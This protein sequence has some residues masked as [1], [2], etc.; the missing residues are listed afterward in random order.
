V[1]SVGASLVRRAHNRGSSVKPTITYF[2]SAAVLVAGLV[3]LAASPATPPSLEAPTLARYDAGSTA[4]R[5]SQVVA[6]SPRRLSAASW[7]GGSYVVAGGERVSLY[8]STS[9]PQTDALAREWAEFF[10]SLVHG[11]EL[12]SLK[13]YIAPQDEV[14]ELC[15]SEHALG[16]YGGQRL[17]TIG[18]S[19]A[20]V[21]PTSIATH[22]YGHHIAANRS[23]APWVALDW[24]TKRWA[25]QA[26]ICARARAGTAFPGDEGANYSL[27]PSEGFAESYRV[28]VETNGT[29]A[30]YDWP[31]VDP[32]FRPSTEALAAIRDDVLHP[33]LAGK[34]RTIHGK[35]LRRSRTWITTVATALDGELRIRVTAPGGGAHDVTLLSSNG[36]TVLSTSSWDSSGGKS[37]GYR[38]CGTRSV[39]VRVTRGV[40]SARF[41]LL[42][43][44]P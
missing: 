37:V 3:A 10:G 16:C 23:N 22:E 44:T 36:R 15:F 27:N 28:L 38:V 32:S 24:G 39:K 20:G 14:S 33:W 19:S 7:W 8:I 1:S 35:F 40:A 9:Y 11:S 31:I 43:T 21:A 12:A 2:A 41:T 6:T 30:G 4:A 13:A 5:R 18:D 34:T 42:V 25:T 29:A 17:V 26:R